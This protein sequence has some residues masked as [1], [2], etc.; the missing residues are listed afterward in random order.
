[1]D[2][3]KI[4]FLIR[5]NK[6]NQNGKCPIYTRLTVNGRRAEIATKKYVV[7]SGY[8]GHMVPPISEHIVPLSTSDIRG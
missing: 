3:V 2:N 5:I 1:M 7:P 8:F 6:I 4:S